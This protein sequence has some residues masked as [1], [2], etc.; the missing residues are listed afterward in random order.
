MSWT[1]RFLA[2]LAVAGTLLVALLTAPPA[3]AHEER[4][5]D[6]PDGSG[7]APVHRDEEPGLLV[8]KKGRAAFE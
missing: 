4:P 3:L 7:S 1:R 2:V 8:C 5:V 6:F